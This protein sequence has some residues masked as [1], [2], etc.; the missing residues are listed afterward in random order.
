[1]RGK[2]LGKVPVVE[3]EKIKPKQ[4]IRV[5]PTHWEGVSSCHNSPTEEGHQLNDGG[6][7]S[8]RSRDERR[9]GVARWGPRVQPG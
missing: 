2:F 9:A 4:N 1:L 3:T 6:D 7:D 8:G 5:T